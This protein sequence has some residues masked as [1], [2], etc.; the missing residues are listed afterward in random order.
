MKP[1]EPEAAPQKVIFRMKL[2]QLLNQR[3]E[4][5]RLAQ[6]INWGTFEQRFGSLYVPHRSR[7]D[8]QFVMHSLQWIE[9]VAAPVFSVAVR[10]AGAGTGFERMLDTQNYTGMYTSSSRHLDRSPRPCAFPLSLSCVMQPP[11]MRTG[12]S[13]GAVP[14][15][16]VA[17]M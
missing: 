1:K 13:C 16:N 15:R 3:H 10:K 8:Q 5:Y 2:E 4:L 12:H 9:K 17:M 14:W 11:F 6:Q 7:L